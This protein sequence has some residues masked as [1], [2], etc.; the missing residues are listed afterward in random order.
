MHDYLY[1]DKTRNFLI[2]LLLDENV[3]LEEC[4]DKH[5][6][7]IPSPVVLYVE[8]KVVFPNVSSSLHQTNQLPHLQMFPRAEQS[9]QNISY[10]DS[11]KTK[12]PCT[13]FLSY[14]ARQND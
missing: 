3:Y 5:I 7:L 11:L 2:L 10:K 4:L 14:I 1:Q 6:N 13:L 12:R 9:N 8:Y